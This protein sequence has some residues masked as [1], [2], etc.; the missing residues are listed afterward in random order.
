[1][2][3]IV[4][5]ISI[6]AIFLPILSFAEVEE[7]SISETTES[8][9][10]EEKAKSENSLS[11]DSSEA[12]SI[13]EN[14]DENSLLAVEKVELD[15][16]LFESEEN[17]VYDSITLESSDSQ[18]ENTENA[19]FQSD[20]SDE[21]RA[22]SSNIGG[23]EI[24]DSEY[25]REMINKY[26]EQFTKD[27]AKKQLC[28]TLENAENYR[29][30][31]RRELKKRDM[32]EAIE[33]LPVVESEYNQYAVSKSGAKGIWQFMENSMRPFMK[34]T[35][36]IDER[37]DPWKSTDAALAK[38]QDNYKIFGD[39][40]IALAAYNCGAGAMQ[41]ILKDAEEKTF[42]FIA[43]KELLRDQSIQ[44]VPK[45]LAICELVSNPEK[46]EI[47]ITQFSEESRFDDFDYVTTNR[48]IS[49]ERIASELKISFKTL[50]DLNSAL[51]KGF[52]PPDS[53]YELR[54]PSGMKD[55][56][57][58]AIGEI[59]KAQDQITVVAILE[60]QKGD[61]LWGISRA[62]GISVDELCAAND[63]IAEAILP[64]GKI[65]YIPEKKAEN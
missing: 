46:Y 31:V 4:F 11:D 33:F 8:V 47:E 9:Q 50:K 24:P 23:I 59:I 18:S 64:I 43:E 17:I 2:K 37:L 54:L 51:V 32:P 44:Y 7:N 3:R 14:E 28:K 20:E 38:L 65:L 60:V 29:L 55:S 61:T 53:E 16:L 56:A 5:F 30:Y 15:D 26:I 27:F 13:S 36:W 6:A 52:T 39:W 57:V 40:A 21:I 34:K 12:D 42:W 49:I 48:K 19:D 1:M 41:R 22:I 63:I 45:L 62:H 25:A 35:E 10:S 58:I